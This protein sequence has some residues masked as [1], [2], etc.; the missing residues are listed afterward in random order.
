MVRPLATSLG[1]ASMKR[2]ALALF[3]FLALGASAYAGDYGT[4]A[5]KRWGAYSGQVPACDD[6]GVL[7]WISK[8]FNYKESEFWNSPLQIASYDRI[9]EI[10]LRANGASFIPRRYCVARAALTDSRYRLVVY[11]TQ[12]DLGFAGLS[13]GIE[14][15][16]MGLDRNLAYAPSCSALRPYITRFLGE[17]AL[18]ERY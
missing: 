17:E 9:R 18:Y 6:P 16:V 10:G 5:E 2:L 1:F 12:E 4:P 3:A 15:C 11:Q 14:W 7:A 13:S 8:M